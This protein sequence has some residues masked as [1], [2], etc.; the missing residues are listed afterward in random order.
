MF[1]EISSYFAK[2]RDK[3][4][5]L[6]VKLK[7]LSFSPIFL[8]M[9]LKRYKNLRILCPAFDKKTKKEGEGKDEKLKAVAHAKHQIN[10]DHP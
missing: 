10:G 4:S 8:Q 9:L 5:L 7:Y 3:T 6:D 1:F 2:K